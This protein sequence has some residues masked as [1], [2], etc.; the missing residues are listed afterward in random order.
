MLLWL[1]GSIGII[2]IVLVFIWFR[3]DLFQKSSKYVEQD[4]FADESVETIIVDGIHK[5]TGL[6]DAAGLTT[7]IQNCTNCHSAKLIIQNRMSKADWEKT[8]DWM[9]ETQNLWDLGSNE[10]VI[11]N[12]LVSNYPIIKKGRRQNLNEIDWYDLKNQ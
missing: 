4:N 1:I 9:Q 10:E 8:I 11:V 2:M 12:Y 7:V 6:K 5:E 3:P